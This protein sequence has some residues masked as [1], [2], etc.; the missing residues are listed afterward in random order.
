MCAGF[1]FIL[2]A[3]VFGLLGIVHFLGLL[4]SLLLMPIAGSPISPGKTRD[5]IG[6]REPLNG[7]TLAMHAAT[8]RGP[9][10]AVA[11][12]SFYPF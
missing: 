2:S 9:S 5:F 11:V 8:Q 6:A 12:E 1:D 3:Q 10:A 7:L 4:R